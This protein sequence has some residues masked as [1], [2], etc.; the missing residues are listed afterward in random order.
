MKTINTN[1][2]RKVAKIASKNHMGLN[3]VFISEDELMATDSYKAVVVKFKGKE[4]DTFPKIPKV[5]FVKGKKSIGI[6][7]SGILKNVPYRN[8]IDSVWS[9]ADSVLANKT[10]NFISLVSTDLESVSEVKFRQVDHAGATFPDI[11]GVIKKHPIPENVIRVDAKLLIEL[12]QT[13]VQDDKAGI[14]TSH[15]DI[16]IPKNGEDVNK[17]APLYLTNENIQGLLMPLKI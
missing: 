1:L 5:T 16:H 6:S 3:R 8:K 10:K 4:L 17:F 15:V 9:I 11:K 7:A 12:L 2:L 14:N 13:F